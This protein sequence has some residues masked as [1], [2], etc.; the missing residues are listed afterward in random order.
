M[1]DS[2]YTPKVV[3][4]FIGPMGGGKSYRVEEARK[5]AEA[6]GRGFLTGDFS[7]GIRETVL[8][9]FGVKGGGA[10]LEPSDKNYLEWKRRGGSISFP[11][12]RGN[13]VCFEYGYRDLLKNVGE[14][15]KRLAGEGVWARWTTQRVYQQYWSGSSESRYKCDIVFGSVRF[16][17]EIEEI[18]G[19]AESINRS[20]KF[21]FCNHNKTAYNPDA[22]VSERLAHVLIKRGYRDGDDV[23]AAIRDIINFK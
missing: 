10:V 23:T 12:G 9:I 13:M 21:I 14:Y 15:L 5:A 16:K 11:D 17:S 2:I 1:D 6:A 7:D 20:V 19:M 4:G 18:Y 8:Q 22:H 3:L